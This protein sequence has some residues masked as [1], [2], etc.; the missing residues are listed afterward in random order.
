MQEKQSFLF[1]Y[2]VNRSY[3]YL[4]SLGCFLLLLLAGCR[5]L[6]LGLLD[7]LGVGQVLHLLVEFLGPEPVFFLPALLRRRHFDNLLN[8]LLGLSKLNL[9]LLLLLVGFPEAF[10]A[11]EIC[12]GGSVEALAH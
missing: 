9:L 2:L 1:N 11:Q 6:S 10:A 12:G 4:D 8:E 5:S 3:T 7:G